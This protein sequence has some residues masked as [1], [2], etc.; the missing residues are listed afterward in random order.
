MTGQGHDGVVEAEVELRQQPAERKRVLEHIR[1]YDARSG[2]LLPVTL[3]YSIRTGPA[4][5]MV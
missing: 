1:G 3:V 2:K 4:L 5:T